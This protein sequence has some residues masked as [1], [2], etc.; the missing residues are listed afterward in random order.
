MK[1]KV[2]LGDWFYNMGIIGFLRIMKD[3]GKEVKQ[4]KGFITFDSEE[5][6]G[7]EEIYFSYFMKQ[8]DVYDRISKN[9]EKSL[10]YVKAHPDKLKDTVKRIKE[11]IKRNADKVKKIDESLHQT[12][13][14]KLKE[15]GS[16]K[17]EE[18]IERLGELVK[19]SLDIFK[20]P[21]INER[22][23]ANLYKFIV[24][25]NF[26][27]QV[28]YFNVAKSSLGLEALKE[29]MYKDYLSE[30]IDYGR[31]HDLL[32]KQD[33]DGV[34]EYIGERLKVKDIGVNIK[35]IFKAIDKILKKGTLQE[36]KTYLESDELA[37][38]EMCGNYSGIVEDYTE[39]HFAPLAVSSGNARNMYWNMNTDYGICAICKLI[40]FCTPAGTTH[41]YKGYLKDEENEFYTFVNMDGSVKELFNMN[42]SLMKSR[43]KE[44]PFEVLIQDLVQ[45]NQ[46]KSEWQLSNILFVEFKA[47]VG[48]KKCTLN[49]FNMPMYLAQFFS[50]QDKQISSI[51]NSKLRASVVDQLIK[52]RDLKHLLIQI[53]HEKI[54]DILEDKKGFSILGSDCY[55]IAKIRFFINRYKGGKLEVDDKKLKVVR[56][57]GENIREKYIKANSKN[58]LGG[59]AYR[60]LNTAK[61]GNKK[62][63]MDTVLRVFVS[64]EEDVPLV[65]LDI[66][67]EKELNFEDIAYAFISG[68]VSDKYD[69]NKEN[70]KE[71]K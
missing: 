11:E 66:M 51:Y 17:K 16:L 47:S 19:E 28:S 49:Y 53:L 59:I 8:Y 45:E 37:S 64:A 23:T 40:L 12:L 50:K 56:Y 62:D 9:L 25:E 43:D 55:K 52:Q 46:Q 70:N 41:I 42:Q 30:I 4:D 54:K 60:L 13:A 35:K 10:A 14:E 33:E 69:P 29:T 31:L 34:K 3:Y 48:E 32:E 5:L 71:D 67:A 36:V 65:F 15:I 6:V 58:K 20:M 26:F 27:G 24:G 68:L 1:I 18:E 57:A 22:L 2:Y 44:N 7:F 38:C 39:S 61:V 63:F 21:I